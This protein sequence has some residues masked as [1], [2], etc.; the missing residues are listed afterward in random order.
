[1]VGWNEDEYTFFEMMSKD[2]SVFKIDFNGL[3]G[4]LQPQ[5]GDDTPKDN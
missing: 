4:K 1:M 2:K 5:F 3:P